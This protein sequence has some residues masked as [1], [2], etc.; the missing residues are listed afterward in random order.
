MMIQLSAKNPDLP[1]RSSSGGGV[2][3]VAL[4]SAPHNP[5]RCEVPHAARMPNVRERRPLACVSLHLE[6]SELACNDVA[7]SA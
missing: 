3:S 4:R 6:A 5:L 7:A 1:A 2:S